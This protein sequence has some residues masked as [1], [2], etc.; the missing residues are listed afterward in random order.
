M[1]PTSPIEREKNLAE[2]H[3]LI[4]R[5]LA[6]SNELATRIAQLRQDI[7]EGKPPPPKKVDTSIDAYKA[8][9]LNKPPAAVRP[10]TDTPKIVKAF[11]FKKSHPK[12]IPPKYIVQN[13]AKMMAKA[14]PPSVPP[15]EE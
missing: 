8:L 12:V 11:D 10:V 9:G 1:S 6:A 4:A 15:T 14:K 7:A 13:I 3:S 5:D 2:M